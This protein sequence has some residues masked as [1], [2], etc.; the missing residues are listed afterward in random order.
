MGDAMRQGGVEGGPVN[1][2]LVAGYDHKLGEV[3]HGITFVILTLEK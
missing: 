2:S 3:E 1:A